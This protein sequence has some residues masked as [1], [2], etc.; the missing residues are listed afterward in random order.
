MQA[1][2]EWEKDNDLQGLIDI[3]EDKVRNSTR[4]DVKWH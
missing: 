1:E 3:D 2:S 4:F